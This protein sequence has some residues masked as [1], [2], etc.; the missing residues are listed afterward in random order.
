M[1]EYRRT[2]RDAAH[3][4]SSLPARVSGAER[5]RGEPWECGGCQ[6][7]SGKGPPIRRL[8]EPS[9]AVF[10]YSVGCPPLLRAPGGSGGGRGRGEHTPR[11]HTS[12]GSGT[13]WRTHAYILNLVL[14]ETHTSTL[15][16]MLGLPARA[17]LRRFGRCDRLL[18]RRLARKGSRVRW[19]RA[20]ATARPGAGAS[21][22]P[23]GQL[24]SRFASRRRALLPRRV[25]LERSGRP[26]CRVAGSRAW[27]VRRPQRWAAEVCRAAS[28]AMP[29]VGQRG[30]R[31]AWRHLRGPPPRC[32]ARWTVARRRRAVG[33]AAWS[34]LCAW[35]GP[36]P[37]RR[38]EL[39]GAAA[40]CRWARR[41]LRRRG[42][43]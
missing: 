6:A 30:F 29:R 34:A 4:N 42:C 15:S 36:G 19:R 25:A 7:L 10:A 3:S 9:G 12:F 22:P 5:A 37:R 17:A 39:L 2:G 8:H 41:L 11:E 35:W 27:R 28:T 18:R 43:S 20:A 16:T 32:G 26:G 38:A 21:L 1:P 40:R 24:G 14:G 31:T 13:P 33:P 23:A